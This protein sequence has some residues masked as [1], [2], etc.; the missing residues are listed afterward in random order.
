MTVETHHIFAGHDGVLFIGKNGR[1]KAGYS[2]EV[3]VRRKM[4]AKPRMAEAITTGNTHRGIVALACGRNG[5]VS[6]SID[7]SKPFS[8][9]VYVRKCT[10]SVQ[11][12]K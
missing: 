5:A 6:L 8:S 12:R 11:V 2:H 4:P 3:L 1:S 7:I 10:R 9:C